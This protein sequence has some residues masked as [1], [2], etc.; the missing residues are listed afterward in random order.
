M[1][2]CYLLFFAITKRKKGDK[3]F[4]VSLTIEVKIHESFVELK[5]KKNLLSDGY[6]TEGKK[7]I[8]CRITIILSLIFLFTLGRITIFPVLYF[9][10]F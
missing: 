3:V 4:L 10:H 1:F 8:L 6:F 7:H 2:P 5:I 9:F